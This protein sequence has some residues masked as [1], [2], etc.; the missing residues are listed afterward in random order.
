MLHRIPGASRN[1]HS[2]GGI[3]VRDRLTDVEERRDAFAL[4]DA[5]AG[6]AVI[7]GMKQ[8]IRDSWGQVTFVQDTRLA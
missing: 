3:A 8:V 1:V 2:R 4:V 6:D 5:A 7:A